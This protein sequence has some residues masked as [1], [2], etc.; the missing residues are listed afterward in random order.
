MIDLGAG[1]GAAVLDAARRSPT[2]LCV[3]IDADAV[4]LREASAR[5]ARPTRRGVPNALFLGADATSLP[6]A[7]DGRADE[8][9]VTLPWGSLLRLVLAGDRRFATDLARALRPAG[10]LRIVVSVEDRDRAAIGGAVADGGLDALAIAL[11]A[12]GL[13][14]A[15]R[16]PVTADDVASL[17]SSWAKRL[18]IPARRA[19]TLLVARKAPAGPPS[20][21]PS[22]REHGQEVFVG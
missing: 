11:E 20:S 10:R 5:A 1:D 6:P 21:S 22:E 2:T 18:G 4:A 7:F 17:R 3:G 14:V 13:D 19:A 16:R 15:G 12:A 8:V 9:T